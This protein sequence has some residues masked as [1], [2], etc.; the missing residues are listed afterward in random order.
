MNYQSIMICIV[1]H[2]Q[3]EEMLTELRPFNVAG[4][5]VLQGE[6]TYRNKILSILGLDET[7]KEVLFLPVDNH[8]LPAIF[9]MFQEQF[10][11]DKRHKG[12][13]FTI[14]MIRYKEDRLISPGDQV[15]PGQFNEACLFVI[16]DHGKSRDVVDYAEELGVKGGTIIH[17]RGAGLPLHLAFDIQITPE[18]DIVLMVTESK[19]LPSLR[20]HLIDRLQLDER[21]NGILFALPVLDTVGFYQEKGGRA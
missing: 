15:D 3:A 5:L 17:G 4:G 8:F 13:A 21:G 7:R 20:S 1:N 12:V 11:L 9:A 18:K 2:G 14:P 6:G 16:T 19:K 10:N